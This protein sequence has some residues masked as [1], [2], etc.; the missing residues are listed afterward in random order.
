MIVLKTKEIH[1]VKQEHIVSEDL[2]M[3]KICTKLVPKVL[4]D[5]Q[6]EHSVEVCKEQ[7]ELCADDPSFLDNVI[8][9]DES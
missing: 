9:G 6:K 4:T 1:K 3:Q 5:A 8:T 2:T 7:K